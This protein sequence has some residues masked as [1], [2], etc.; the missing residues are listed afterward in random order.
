MKEM[1]LC[2]VLHKCK[3]VKNTVIVG[4]GEEGRR[5]SKILIQNGI[6]IIEFFDNNGEIIGNKINCIRICKPHKLEETETLYVVSV[7]DKKQKEELFNQLTDLDINDEDII[8][9]NR[10][11]SNYEY[12]EK[13][14][15][16]E[17]RNII[18][19]L[20]LEKFG[21]EINFINP[22][23]YNEKINLEKINLSDPIRTK[24]AD[25]V[26]VRKWIEEQ[27]GKQYLTKHYGVWK[28]AED[29]DFGILPQAF[30]LKMNN[31]SGRNILV[32]DK[33][34]L[35]IAS[36][37]K[38]LNEWK[39]SNYA[40][41][42]MEL[43]YR[44][45]IPQIICEEY[46]KDLAETVYDYNIYCFN[47]EPRY[48]WCI[49]GSHRPNCKASFYDTNWKMQPFS[50]GY[51]K[52][53][54]EAPRPEKLDEILDLSRTLCKQ[55]KHVRVDWY[56][57]PDGRVLFGEMTFATWAGLAKFIPEE[58]DMIFGKLIDGEM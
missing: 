43:H 57:M 51:P 29:I 48:I 49:K 31:G 19:N 35:D 14:D 50:Y 34:K 41:T 24:L 26:E 4:A 37:I 28:N 40:F 47:G 45:I 7:R 56:N 55:F 10:D 13:A 3:E 38:Q 33:N 25:K 11:G 46:L 16:N 32:K 8:L 58:Y 9:Y 6:K 39:Q 17:Y 20:Y 2:L 15:E 30:V 21:H 27:I 53:E 12:N 42:A 44:D 1:M 22:K 36:T 52:D 23:T 54:E 5:L 18:N